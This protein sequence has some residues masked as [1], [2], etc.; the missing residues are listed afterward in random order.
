MTFI[1]IVPL[2]EY[3]AQGFEIQKGSKASDCV[4]V[5]VLTF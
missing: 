1:S 3:V 5:V 4:I 2:P